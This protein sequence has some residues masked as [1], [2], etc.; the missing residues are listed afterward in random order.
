MISGGCHFILSIWRQKIYP[1][2]Y[3]IYQTVSSYLL[4]CYTKVFGIS[5]AAAGPMCLIVR[6]IDAVADP[7]IGAVTDKTNTTSCRFLPISFIRRLFGYGCS[8]SL[9]YN[10][11]VFGSYESICLYDLYFII[12]Y[13]FSD[14]F[15]LY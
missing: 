6:L 15:L 1:A 3:F 7:F 8:D 5:A 4:F 10:S 9:F 12:H 2:T 13:I 11:R 14:R